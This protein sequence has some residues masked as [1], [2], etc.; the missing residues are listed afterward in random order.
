SELTGRSVR[1]GQGYQRTLRLQ[2]L[3]FV[4]RGARRNWTASATKSDNFIV[5]VPTMTDDG[6]SGGRSV[7]S[8]KCR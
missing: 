1:G 3:F 6:G 5:A 4:L 7:L 2:M 8:F